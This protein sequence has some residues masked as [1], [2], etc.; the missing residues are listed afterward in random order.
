M[1][2]FLLLLLAL[3]PVFPAFAATG[4][5]PGGLSE[6]SVKL[7]D[8]LRKMAGRGQLSP[9]TGALVSIGAPS[10]LDM[11]HEW[12][13]LIISATS[14]PEFN[15]S[16]LLLRAYAEVALANGWII[17]AVDPLEKITVE[18]DDVAMRLALN[19]AALAVLKQQWPGTGASPLAFGGFSGGAKYS[20]WMAAAF[21]SQGRAVIGL[22]LAGINQDTLVPAAQ[23]FNVMNAAFRRIPIYLQSAENDEVATPDAHREVASQLADMGF[24]NVRIEV[25]PGGHQ[26]EPLPLKSALQW[27][28]QFAAAPAGAK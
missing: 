5:T 21:F 17:L 27:F 3:M 7:P 22:Y 10:N 6:F 28:R 9:V 11:A 4:L 26:V 25:F 16:R 13:V 12:P 19:T 23:T 24:K 8:D 20:S 14:D 1:R 18:Q 15:S 2:R